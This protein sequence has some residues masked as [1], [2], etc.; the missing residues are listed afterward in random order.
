[1]KIYDLVVIGS[2]AGMMTA[3][4]AAAQ[5]LS[6]ALI[7]GNKFG[8][9]CLNRGCIPSKTLVYPADLI[10]EGQKAKKVGVNLKFE[11]IDWT[12]IS[13]RMWMQIN[14]NLKIRTYLETVP[15]LDVYDGYGE[16]TSEDT[17]RVQRKDMTYS[18]PFK[19]KKILIATGGHSFLPEIPGLE[20]AKCL[21]SEAF[22][23]DRHPEKLY[24][25]MTILGGGS[26]AVE[27]AHILSA[28]GVK[29]RL[30]QRSN[31][32][33]KKEEPVIS[34]YVH[35]Q[36]IKDGVE[37]WTNQ[38]IVE[39]AA[40]GGIKKVTIL[41]RD[42]GEKQVLESEEILVAMGIVPNTEQLN[43]S[44]TG[45]E[46]DQ[47]GWIMTD[48]YLRT[49][50]EHIFALGDINGKYQ[51]RHKANY[52]AEFFIRNEILNHPI[53]FQAEYHK[54]PW[55]VYCHPQVA[56]FGMTEAEALAA[57]H[58]IK[59][60]T[61]RYSE[62]AKGFAMGYS[63]GDE[64]DGFVKLITDEKNRILGAHV[65]G[66]HAAMLV[67]PFVY[68]ASVG[69]INSARPLFN[70]REK[71]VPFMWGDLEPLYNAMTIHPSLSEVSA[72]TIEK[73]EWHSAQEDKDE[74]AE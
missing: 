17:L 2:G 25:S 13:R 22:F 31:R 38:K 55:A 49:N 68:L 47:D 10:R 60:A 11:G 7:E 56:H 57:G 34:D 52:E 19:G 8:G 28:F 63:P 18:E 20:E 23:G 41:N 15:N 46:L 50:K 30:V 4:A 35:Q 21:T 51:F 69:D 32:I 44:V 59:I 58:K 12:M 5:G 42:S 65:V 33:L 73:L 36:L 29:V 61:N 24:E 74:Q 66:A 54:V 16:F 37:V 45:V 72:W 62:V 39:I 43:L 67:Q 53:R 9:T 3:Q 26:I 6:C 1:M 27:F 48:A 40:N 70:E 14:K 71:E 64:D